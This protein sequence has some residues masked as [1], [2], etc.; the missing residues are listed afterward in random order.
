MDGR[1]ESQEREGKRGRE[2][3]M[4]ENVCNAW[5]VATVSPTTANNIWKLKLKMLSNV[6]IPFSSQTNPIKFHFRPPLRYTLHL[7][8]AHMSVVVHRATWYVLVAIAAE[9]VNNPSLHESPRIENVHN[10]HSAQ[11]THTDSSWTLM[12]NC[13]YYTLI[14]TNLYSLASSLNRIDRE[15]EI[16]NATKNGREIHI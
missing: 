5:L 3:K 14:L 6:S 2:V 8:T 12:I 9:H 16:D 10:I 4:V 13:Y 11:H 15:R 7:P 1:A